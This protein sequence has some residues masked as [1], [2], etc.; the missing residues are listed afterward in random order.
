MD[1]ISLKMNDERYPIAK[2][3]LLLFSTGKTI[4]IFG[5]VIFNFALGLYVLKLTGSALS[6]SMTLI[7]S[8]RL[9][10]NFETGKMSV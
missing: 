1:A 5:N 3:N 8:Q 10:I 9:E 7:I 6:C 2:K 4:S